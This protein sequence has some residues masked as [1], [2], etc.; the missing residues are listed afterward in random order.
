[1]REV[2][3]DSGMACDVYSGVQSAGVLKESRSRIL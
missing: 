2:C 1:M 3:V